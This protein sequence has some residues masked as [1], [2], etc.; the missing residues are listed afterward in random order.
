MMPVSVIYMGLSADKIGFLM[1]NKK[2]KG[3]PVQA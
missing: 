1:A 2:G 3:I